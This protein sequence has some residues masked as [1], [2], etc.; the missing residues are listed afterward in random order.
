M[1]FK[2]QRTQS[3]YGGPSHG[4]M[5]RMLVGQVVGVDHLGVGRLEHPAQILP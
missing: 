2:R 3:L 4:D 5:R 1:D